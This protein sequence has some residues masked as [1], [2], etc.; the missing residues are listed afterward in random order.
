MKCLKQKFCDRD[1]DFD[2]V[3]LRFELIEYDFVNKAENMFQ[4]HSPIFIFHSLLHP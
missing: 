2:K 1:N 4:K 3:C